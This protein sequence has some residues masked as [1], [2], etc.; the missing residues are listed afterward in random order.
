MLHIQSKRK[1]NIYILIEVEY[2]FYKEMYYTFTHVF[3]LW[4]IAKDFIVVKMANC[5]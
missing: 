1:I 5:R 4:Q 3:F 2:Q